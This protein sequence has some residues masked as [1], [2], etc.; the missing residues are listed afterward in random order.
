MTVV[1]TVKQYGR[2]IDDFRQDCDEGTW[3]AVLLAYSFLR[4]KG[5]QAGPRIA[6]K[7]KD[8]DGIWELLAGYKNSEPRLLF[9]F[10]PDVRGLMIFV[11]AFIKKGEKDYKPAIAL[12]Q[13]RRT[14]IR[15][16]KAI[17]SDPELSRVH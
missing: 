15:L 7:L 16:G 1:W 8:A 5:T 17:P 12:A 11:H 6:R 3:K 4:A 10:S 13:Q 14:L 9:Y 2:V